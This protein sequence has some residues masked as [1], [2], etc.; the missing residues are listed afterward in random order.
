MDRSLSCHMVFTST[1]NSKNQTTI[2]KA[3]MAALHARPSDTLCFEL[4]PDGRVTLTAKSTSFAQLTGSFPKKTP[5][6]AAS[7]DEMQ[8]AIRAGAARG[9]KRP[10]VSRK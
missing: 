9:F 6:K 4:G 1:L 2:P 3:V 10:K 5:A 7:I 8:A